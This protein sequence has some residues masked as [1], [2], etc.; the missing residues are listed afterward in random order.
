MCVIYRELVQ[1][2]IERAETYVWRSL[3]Q[4]SRLPQEVKEGLE[5]ER[6]PER[7]SDVKS[8]TFS[9]AKNTQKPI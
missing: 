3:S 7:E 5:L 4:D 8:F 1:R 9:H 2:K 6:E